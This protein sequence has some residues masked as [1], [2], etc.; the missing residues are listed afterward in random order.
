[1]N[2]LYSIF[3]WEEEELL[4]E[5]LFL[6]FSLETV[7]G[8]QDVVQKRTVWSYAST[9]NS[10][11]ANIWVLVQIKTQGT[12]TDAL[13]S[14]FSLHQSHVHLCKRVLGG[15]GGLYAVLCLVQQ[16]QSRHS[17]VLS[18][19]GCP[20]SPSCNHT[21]LCPTNSLFSKYV[22]MLFHKFYINVTM[23]SMPFWDWVL[24]FFFTQRNFLK[25]HIQ[26]VTCTNNL[27]PFLAK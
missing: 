11:H 5:L 3:L 26:V 2:L 6:T 16:P 14:L 21:L 4:E 19:Q 20:T 25:V 27:F 1:M 24:F 8:L 15:A 7:I 23:K 18:P 22:I 9:L 12:G 17:P 10:P 13:Q